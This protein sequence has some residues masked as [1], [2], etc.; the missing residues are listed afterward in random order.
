MRRRDFITLLGGAAAVWPIAARG[1]QAGPPL[2]GFL[3][4]TTRSDG[5]M[6]ERLA[7]FH[8]GL[9]DGGF[10]EGVNVAVEYRW[11]EGNN[12][13]LAGLAAELV[14]RGVKVIT[15]LESTAGV[16]AAEAATTT[17]PIVFAIGGDPVKNHLV[18]SLS[19]P[20][21]NVTG[22]S[23]VSNE[24]GPKRLG[25]LRDLLPDASTLAVLFNPTNPNAA[26]D[27]KDLQDA[28]P[29]VGLTIKLFAASNERE[30]DAFFA[31]LVRESIPAFVITPD[32]LF[33]RRREQIVV[34][35]S[36]NAIPAMYTAREFVAAGGLISYGSDPID[37]WRQEGIYVSR[38]LK[39]EKPGDLPVVQPTRFVLAI[40]LKTAKELGL[41]IP[42]TLQ[43]AADE[44]IE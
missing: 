34:L 8:R 30:I 3:I 31:I 43:Y 37:W 36:Y 5:A 39:G 11:A 16:L 23:G 21:G 20:G 14:S 12:D 40:N 44:V 18:A 1:Q 17:I 22:V 35:A 2:I 15:G 38:I 29:S 10:V 32:P 42:L 7:A 33:N 24:L 4:G 19:H 26:S 6:A 27:A 25:L 41:T 9:K 28:A 13:R